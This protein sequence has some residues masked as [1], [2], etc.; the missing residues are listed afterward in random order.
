MSN[1]FRSNTRDYAKYLIDE[2]NNLIQK[3]TLEE[4][5]ELL[6]DLGNLSKMIRI[7]LHLES[8]TGKKDNLEYLRN[9][10]EKLDEKKKFYLSPSGIF[11]KK[12]P[13]INGEQPI[14]MYHRDI[15]KLEVF[16]PNGNPNGNNELIDVTLKAL[17]ED[18]I[19]VEDFVTEANANSKVYTKSEE[20]KDSP[21]H[22]SRCLLHNNYCF[23]YVVGLDAQTVFA[24][25]TTCDEAKMIEQLE[26][27][28]FK[29]NQKRF[30]TE[31]NRRFY[32][33]E[34]KQYFVNKSLVQQVRGPQ[35][36]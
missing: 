33:L 17:E 10:E 27:E 9:L 19:S 34:M 36:Q 11:F 20:S 21:Y 4:V 22:N 16:N 35:R 3:A 12:Q 30:A 29:L 25:L 6:E 28:G 26:R 32:M 31:G 8:L 13:N 1:D 24:M 23:K 14:Y 15:D 7:H 18:Y 5:Y 2:Y